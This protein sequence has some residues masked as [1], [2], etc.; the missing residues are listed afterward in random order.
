[1][2]GPE[3]DSRLCPAD[4]L[5]KCKGKSVTVAGSCP[6]MPLAA[7]TVLLGVSLVFDVGYLFTWLQEKRSRCSLRLGRGYLLITAP[8]DLERV[9]LSALLPV[10]LR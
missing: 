2:E 3:T 7:P 5:Q 10:D 9:A 1:M 6:L 4:C 8:P